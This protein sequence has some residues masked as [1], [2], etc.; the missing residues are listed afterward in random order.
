MSTTSSSLLSL[1][2]EPIL[3][4]GLLLAYNTFT[5]SGVTEASLMDAAYLAAANLV[6]NVITNLFFASSSTLTTIFG[7]TANTTMI[8][9]SFV[10]P[11]LTS[12]MYVYAYD[13]YYKQTYNV[14]TNRT[15]NMSYIVSFITTAIS[16]MYS[17]SIYSL[18]T[19]SFPSL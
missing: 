19:T 17:G 4:G 14:S 3:T 12:I 16:D 5:G 8:E 7:T 11:I 1:L 2:S 6:A 18:L 9:Q 10:I 15:T 13:T